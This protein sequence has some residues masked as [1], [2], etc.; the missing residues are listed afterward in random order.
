M[1]REPIPFQPG[2]ILTLRDPHDQW[3]TSHQHARPHGIIIKS[4]PSLLSPNISYHIL[5]SNGAYE[6]ELHD[7]VQN[8]YRKLE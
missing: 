2:T 5:F 8:V 1:K 7:Y 3:N 6:Y 4:Y